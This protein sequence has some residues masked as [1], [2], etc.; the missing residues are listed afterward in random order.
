MRLSEKITTKCG[1]SLFTSLRM[2]VILCLNKRS[3]NNG[4]FYAR[5][6]LMSEMLKLIDVK[7]RRINVDDNGEKKKKKKTGYSQKRQ[8]TDSSQL[9]LEELGI[10]ESQFTVSP[11]FTRCI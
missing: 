2:S 1:E 9:F 8:N 3:K 11:F 10:G 6:H 5:E 4:C 7:L